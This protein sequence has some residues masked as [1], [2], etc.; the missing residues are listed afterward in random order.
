MSSQKPESPNQSPS[1]NAGCDASSFFGAADLAREAE[2]ARVQRTYN[3]QDSHEGIVDQV[4]AGVSTGV[5]QP[6]SPS[7]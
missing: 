7:R 4:Q 2:K 1:T 3:Q 6:P 5:A